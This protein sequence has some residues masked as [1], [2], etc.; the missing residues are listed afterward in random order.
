MPTRSHVHQLRPPT[1]SDKLSGGAYRP[2]PVPRDI[3]RSG[4]HERRAGVDRETVATWGAEL[5]GTQAQE[6][7]KGDDMEP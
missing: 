3:G 4:C 6:Q 1:N 2:W 7:R 5:V